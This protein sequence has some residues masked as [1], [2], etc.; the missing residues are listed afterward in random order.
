MNIP[1]ICKGARKVKLQGGASNGGTCG[2]KSNKLELFKFMPTR[3]LTRSQVSTIKD[4][5]AS[6]RARYSASGQVT[7]KL[8]DYGEIAPGNKV[9]F[10]H[11][12]YSKCEVHCNGK[13]QTVYSGR[14]R[15]RHRKTFDVSKECIGATTMVLKGGGEMRRL[16][17]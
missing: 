11:H 10:G 1:E 5:A 16:P 13:K 9:N 17:D 6:C 12:K 8:D 4:R 3:T 14:R 2:F 15:H 7:I